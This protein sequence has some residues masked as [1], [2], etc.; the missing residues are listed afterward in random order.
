MKPA[1]WAEIHRLH[2]IEHLSH[3]QIAIKVGCSRHMV[4]QALKSRQ[5]PVAHANPS[6]AKIIDPFQ[7]RI[8]QILK[9][10]PNLS[11]VRILQKIAKPEGN[12]PGY[13]GGITQL[14]IYLKSVRAKNHRVYQ[15]AHYD[16]GEAMQIDWGNVGPI[17]IGNAKRTVSVFVAVLCY[18]RVIYIEFTLSQRK[19]EFYRCVVNALRFFGGSPRKVMFDNLKAAVISG[20]GRT[21]VLHP[22]FAALCGTYRM[23]PIACEAHDPESKG[24]VENGVGYVKRNAL[25]G[26]DDEMQAWDDYKHLAIDWRDNVANTRIHDR[27]G[28]KPIERFEQEKLSLRSLPAVHY[29]ADETLLTEVYPTAQIKFDCNRYSVP[30]SLARRTVTIVANA[31]TI[32]IL[33]QGNQVAEHRRCYG[34]RES[35]TEPQHKIDALILRRRQQATELERCFGAL[36]EEAR[37]FQLALSKLPVRPVVHLRRIQE[38]V[39]LYGREVVLQAMRAAIEYQTIDAA[40]V[41]T[42]VLQ[43]RRKA[44]LPSPTPLQPKRKD[45]IQLELDIPDPSRYDHL[46]EEKEPDDQSQT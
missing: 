40:Y 44:S 41:E 35:I 14:R 38:L 16:P 25:A 28:Q 3:R 45:L 33:H 31:D 27:I 1:I 10:Y 4:Q 15:E 37:A 11:A 42:I 13:Q 30:P 6:R 36:G 32:R 19:N 9:V 29:N 39:N 18:S 24:R 7:E 46:L 8:A 2:E 23:E 20:S 26:R 5:P 34:K 12:S 43:E 21:A 22:E 17:S